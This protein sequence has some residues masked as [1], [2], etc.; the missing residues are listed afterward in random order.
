MLYAD[1]AISFAGWTMRVSSWNHAGFHS[2][3][4]LN[5]ANE[6]CDVA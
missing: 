4:I 3:R 6:R 2:G 5:A 1:R